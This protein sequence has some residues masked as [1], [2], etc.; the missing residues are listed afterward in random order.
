M[1]KCDIDIFQFHI[2]DCPAVLAAGLSYFRL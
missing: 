2:N 1:T